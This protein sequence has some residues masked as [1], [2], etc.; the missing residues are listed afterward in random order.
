MNKK[1]CI[2]RIQ[3]EIIGS[4]SG[5]LRSNGFFEILPPIIAENTDPGLRGAHIAKIDFYGKP[6]CITSSINIQKFEAIKYLEKIFAISQVVR[7]EEPSKRFTGRHLSEFSIIEVEA[8]NKNYNEIMEIGENLI[9]HI[10]NSVLYKCS[11][12][13]DFLGRKLTPLKTPFKKFSHTEV[14]EI[15]KAKGFNAEYGEEI[16]FEAEVE[17]SRMQEGFV[18]ITD[19]PNGSRGFYDR[20]NPVKPDFLKDFDLIMPEGFGEVV[21]GGE[22]E[23]SRE[24]ITRQM[25]KTGLNPKDYETFLKLYDDGT[26]LPSSGFGIGIERL[27]RFICGLKHVSEASMFPKLPGGN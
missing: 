27:T 10:I 6:F 9:C 2:F 11:A 14:V 8:A 1:I 22:R 19:Y 4:A 17:F 18:W 12:E 15:L 3:S 26:M 21:S 7:L 25:L 16:P 20:M 23:F 5:F 13:L 24:G